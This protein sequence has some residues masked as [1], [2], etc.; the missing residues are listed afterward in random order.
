MPAET[1]TLFVIR[2]VRVLALAASGKGSGAGGVVAVLMLEVVGQ[3]WLFCKSIAEE[4]E[5]GEV[6]T[7][8]VAQFDQFQ[9]LTN[10]G[11]LNFTFQHLGELGFKLEEALAVLDPLRRRVGPAWVLRAEFVTVA[12]SG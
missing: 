9:P 5:R 10:I 4:P 11:R 6:K 3:G 12:E 8:V 7:L 1:G 2:L